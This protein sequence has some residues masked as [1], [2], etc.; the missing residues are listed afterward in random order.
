LIQDVLTVFLTSLLHNWQYLAVGIMMAAA[1]QAFVDERMIKTVFYKSPLL[2]I[3]L[4]TAAGAFTPLCSCGTVA[5]ILSLIGS[6][7]PWGPVVAFLVSSPLMS[8]SIYVLTAG[9]IGAEVANAKVIA[10]VVLGLTAG[11][12]A[13]VMERK[14]LFPLAPAGIVAG[15][16][17]VI[18]EDA[19]PAEAA[20]ASCCATSVPDAKP[21][22]CSAEVPSRAGLG[23]E[24]PGEVRPGEVRPGAPGESRRRSL[25]DRARFF[26]RE[27]PRQ[28]LFI[29]K[30]FLLFALIGSVLQ[31]IVPA[32]VVQSLMGQGRIYSVPV[33]ALIGTP[34]YVSGTSAIPLIGSLVKLGMSKGAALSFLI[35]G[36]GTSV[37]AL[38]AVL[39]VAPR[40][41]FWLYLVTVFGGAILAGYT[42]DL[43]F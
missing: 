1:I 5:V 42:F 20:P 12:V 39:A 41:V 3:G 17:V 15:S 35:A 32:S 40:R 37:G 28:A 4:A 36:P 16:T 2:S 10:T 9:Y 29:L 24:R 26:A 33:A 6:G 23:Q 30:W 18:P 14:I 27:L 25:S 38:G 13:L 11:F 19:T 21:C 31:V 22:G 43:L 7:V 8:P 34:L